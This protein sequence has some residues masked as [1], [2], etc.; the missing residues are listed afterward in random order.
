MAI[1]VE[2]ADRDH[3]E[4]RQ[5]KQGPVS[6]SASLAFLSASVR[7][8]RSPSLWHSVSSGSPP[9]TTVFSDWCRSRAAW[10]VAELIR[11]SKAFPRFGGGAFPK[12]QWSCTRIPLGSLLSR[13]TAAQVSEMRSTANFHPEWGYLAPAPSFMRR[14]RIVLLATAIGVTLGAGAVFSWGSHQATELS[15]AARTLVRPTEAGSAG[16]NTPAQATQANAPSSN[17]KW[18]LTVNSRSAD[19]AANKTSTGSTTRAPEGMAAVAEV[20]ATTDRLAIATIAAPPTVTKDPVLNVAPIKKKTTKKS[21]ATWRFASREE[22][23]GLTPGEHYKRR[24]WGGYYGDTG[25]SY[26]NWW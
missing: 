5:R 23:F 17:E 6:C 19:G 4:K 10:P 8:H 15:V 2:F 9:L 22:P 12:V 7:R 14:A 26:R 1:K 16:A 21:N 11:T 13:K 18:P 25:G 24:S 20:P 3:T